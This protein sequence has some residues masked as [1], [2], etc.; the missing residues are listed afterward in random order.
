MNT[1]KM[2]AS[3]RATLAAPSCPRV[4][5]GGTTPRRVRATRGVVPRASTEPRELAAELA[6]LVQSEGGTDDARVLTVIGQLE[7]VGA[8]ADP[9]ALEGA[10][11]VAWSEGTMAWRALVAKA[12]QAIAGRSR[13]GQ[14]FTPGSPGEALN[15]A[16]LFD[17]RCV[18]TAWGVFRPKPECADAADDAKVASDATYPLGFDVQISGG[19]LRAF[20]KRWELPICGPGEFEVLYGDERVRVFRS[21]GG[22]AVQVPS[23]WERPSDAQ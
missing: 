1:T 18:I 6:S 22:V 21:S 16:E 19:D 9:R 11:E 7:A 3:T 12:V 2:Y 5:R 4:V 20:G 17:G 23:D 8:P 10:Y 15:F 14:W 13:A